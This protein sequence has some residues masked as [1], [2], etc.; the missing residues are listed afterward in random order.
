MIN[1]ILITL[2][3]NLLFYHFTLSLLMSQ[4]QQP[5]DPANAEFDTEL[6][7]HAQLYGRDGKQSQ[8]EGRRGLSEDDGFIIN[9]TTHP[10]V[11]T[12]TLYTWI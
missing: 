12:S 2:I 5:C 4:N 1:C 8:H 3:S 10:V 9:S 11:R 7:S 6:M